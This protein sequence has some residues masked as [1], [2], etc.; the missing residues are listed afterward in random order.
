MRT[1]PPLQTSL[2]DG[3]CASVRKSSAQESADEIMGYLTPDVVS[4]L[5]VRIR[6]ALEGDRVEPMIYVVHNDS[7]PPGGLMITI[8][9][10]S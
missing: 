8:L 6:R 2:P 3:A 7:T 9:V 10:K 5:A 1:T 4:G